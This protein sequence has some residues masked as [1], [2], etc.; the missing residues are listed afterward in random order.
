MLQRRPSAWSLTDQRRA[1]HDQRK[2]RGVHRGVQGHHR[3]SDVRQAAQRYRR[4][5]LQLHETRAHRKGQDG[6]LKQRK[7]A[8]NAL[9]ENFNNP[10]KPFLPQFQ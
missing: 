7:V 8:R 3:G 9:M 4:P 10:G 2:L 1:Q 6:L 5:G